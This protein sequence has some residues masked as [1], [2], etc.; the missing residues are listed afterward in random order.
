MDDVN[1][2]QMLN[3]SELCMYAYFTVQIIW[4]IVKTKANFLVLQAGCLSG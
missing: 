2:E 1:M 3:Q 4:S